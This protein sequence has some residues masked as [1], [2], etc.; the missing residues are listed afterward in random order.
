MIAS[1]VVKCIDMSLNFF[2][3]LVAASF[4]FRLNNCDSEITVR[5]AMALN[6][7]ERYEEFMIFDQYLKDRVTKEAVWHKLEKKE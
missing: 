6:T 3:C 1:V 2:H 4:G 5:I 7:A